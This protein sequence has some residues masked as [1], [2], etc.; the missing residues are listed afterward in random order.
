MLQALRFVSG[1]RVYSSYVSITFFCLILT[2]AMC[3][4]PITVVKKSHANDR[5]APQRPPDCYHLFFTPDGRSL[6]A[7]ASTGLHVWDIKSGKRLW[8]WPEEGKG[9]VSVAA[10]SP[11]SKS[12][13]VAS[14]GFAYVFETRSGKTEGVRPRARISTDIIAALA[15]SPDGKELAV[16]TWGGGVQVHS[17]N[18]WQE[19]ARWNSPKGK[20]D[21]ERVRSMV[22]SQDGKELF[23]GIDN[24]VTRLS[25]P[26]LRVKS[27]YE[28]APGEVRSLNL[29]ANGNMLIIASADGTLHG[30]GLSEANH[31]FS[32][33][34]H[35]HVV[36][37]AVELKD[38]QLA[39][40]GTDGYIRTWAK[41][42]RSKTSE[43]F[44]DR[45]VA[46]LA[47]SAD[48]SL[49]ATG[50]RTVRLW[51]PANWTE[52]PFHGELK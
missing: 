45:N 32:F 50:G 7:A 31:S 33:L 41:D 47:S 4:S 18:H 35:R 15:F 14:A 38:G 44:V 11:D 20:Y 1:T 10:V 19:S 26:G 22:Y 46:C 8:R 2:L 51:K 9:G 39:T 48:G 27:K 29:L 37:Q 12:L 24:E 36:W 5:V 52:I 34:A 13:V 40:V 16:G 23:V 49:I 3:E 28:V 17:T 43:H 42:K 21:S 30:W 6:V 25:C